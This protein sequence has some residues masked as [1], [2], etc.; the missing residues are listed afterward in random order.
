LE[1][2]FEAKGEV[3]LGNATIGGNLDCAGGEF[4]SKDEG[5]ALD[6]SSAKINGNLVCDRGQ[7][8]C[9]APPAI[10]ANRAKVNGYVYFREGFKASGGVNLVAAT[11]GGN[12]DCTRATFISYDPEP[13]LDC[14][15][16]KI[17]GN[18]FL[19]DGAQFLRNGVELLRGET[20]NMPIEVGEKVR[21]QVFGALGPAR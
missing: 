10:N 3:D 2:G 21:Q 6:L 16:T 17:A 11:I 20:E 12:L 4:A 14:D 13:A 9:G 5:P 19:R 8:T 15:S 7:F 1:Q 18:V